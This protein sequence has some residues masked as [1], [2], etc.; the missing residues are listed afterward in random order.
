VTRV[1]L[2]GLLGRKV[3]ASLTALAVVLGVAMVS[4][5]FVLTDTISKAFTSI[6]SSA[7]DNTDA[8]VSGKK[9]VDYSSSGNATVSPDTLALIR[10]QPYVAS[11]AGA[12]ADLNGDSTRAKLIGKDGKAIDNG[13]APT[14]GFGIDTSQPRF[15][16]LKLEEG[17]WAAAA[18][19][20][21]I[22]P[23]TAKDEHFTVG[24]SIGVAA[25][26]PV[27][28]FR[29]VGIAKYG[30]VESL[31]GATFA[32]F[33][34]PEARR[35][36]HMDGF[37]AIAVAAKGDLS[38][39]QLA[40]RLQKL[41]PG[42]AQVKTAEEQ[43]NADKKGIAGFLTF[44]RGFLLGF[45][46]IALFVGAFVI[47]NTLSITVAQRT[48]E[49][50]TLRTLG[51]TRRQ[52]LRSVILESAAIGLLAS[53]VGLLSGFGLARGLSALFGALGLGLPEAAPVYALHTF[54]VSLLLGVLV[55]VLA[56]LVPA[57]RSTR[58]AP[59]AAA[60]GGMPQKVRGRRATIAGVVLLAVAALLLGYAVTGDRLG[61]G[62]SLLALGIGALALI[63]G[64]AGVAS[65]L[66]A[67]LAAVL[68]WPFRRFGGAAGRIASENA[69]RNPQRT[70]S[71]AAALMIGIALVSFVAVLGRGVHD[72]MNN[73][74]AQQFPAAW[75]VT[76]KNGWSGFPVAAGDA[77]AKTPGV[78]SVTS[79]RG[80]RGLIGDTQVNVDGVDPS[81][82]S[83]LYHFEWKRGSSE[84]TLAELSN[85]GAL[86]KESF[87]KKSH[88]ELGQ[89]FILLGSSGKPVSLHVAG[90]YQPP[91]I[92]ELLGG[93]VVSQDAFDTAFPRA[94]NQ[95]TLIDGNP[96]KAALA[97]ALAAFPDTKVQTHAEFVKNQTSFMG[98]LLNLVYVLLALS[99]VVSLFGMVNTLVLSVWERTREIGMLRAVGMSRRQARRM[100]RHESIVTA[101]IGA[102]LGMPL[103]VLLAYAVTHALSRFGVEFEVSVATLAKF[104]L[105]AIV[106]GVLAAIAP[107]RR[108]SKLNVLSALQYE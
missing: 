47:F 21:V 20:V 77:A 42:T 103:G 41:V 13:G 68:G 102:G 99:V 52:V 38:Q 18:D 22:D 83:G 26:G 17:R 56:G 108:A 45:G 94:Q 46:G 8:V 43:A 104:A 2:K 67:A 79:I 89:Q 96:S 85:G 29:I 27:Q 7:Y 33:T 101:L 75:V 63:S 11:A 36:L 51:A 34:I 82:V 54:V 87:A 73:A 30:D 106:A 40:G 35:L 95:F 100:V 86:V 24:D 58:I 93:V 78:T 1:A 69:V 65:R 32:V 44:I 37:T 70:A 80:D 55:T 49:L 71:T 16:P 59:I 9:L 53:V 28:R 48:R 39:D 62:S 50:A 60:R 90:F 23:D 105:V 91:R 3:R 12:I 31:G 92:A 107:A 76:S 84:S 66:V 6:F 97:K 72:S 19:E 74:I 15:N 25:V 14:F 81:T 57:F 64:T 88:L 5:S 61:S 98:S 10:K 4:G